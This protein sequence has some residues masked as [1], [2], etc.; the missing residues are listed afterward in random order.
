MDL[1][2]EAHA[3]NCVHLNEK[4]TL[5]FTVNAAKTVVG[6]FQ[7]LRRWSNIK[8]ALVK[9]LMFAGYCARTVP[10]GGGRTR[11]IYLYMVVIRLLLLYYS[12]VRSAPRGRDQTPPQKKRIKFRGLVRYFFSSGENSEWPDPAHQQK[13]NTKNTHKNIQPTHFRVFLGFF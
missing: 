1:F 6:L 11:G 5:K 8:P 2:S 9:C 13:K 10:M 12:T 4:A 7:A 3:L